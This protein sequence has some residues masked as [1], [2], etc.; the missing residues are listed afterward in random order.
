MPSGVLFLLT[1][2]RKSRNQ[3]WSATNLT[4]AELIARV[5]DGDDDA[6]AELMR[7]H[8]QTVFRLAHLHLGD[9]ADAEDAAQECFI[10]AYRSLRS[11]DSS[12]PLRPWL[13]R[14]VSNLALNRRRSMGRYWGALQRAAQEQPA[15]ENGLAVKTEKELEAKELWTAVKRLPGNMQ[16]VIYLRYFLD[17]SVEET[18]STLNIAEGTVKSQT[19]RALEKLQHVI[20]TEFPHLEQGE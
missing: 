11:F 6:W 18:S 5:R 15:S 12:R 10:N 4:E 8:Q 19:H 13:L 17:L 16:N 2:K 3:I 1:T 20:R 7:L 14:I 9:A